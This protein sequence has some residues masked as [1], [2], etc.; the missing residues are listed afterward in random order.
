LLCVRPGR[1]RDRRRR[2]RRRARARAHARRR[3][4]HVSDRLRMRG[5]VATELVMNV[6]RS[7]RWDDDHLIVTP[8]RRF[9]RGRRVTREF[10]CARRVV[11]VGHVRDIYGGR[12]CRAQPLELGAAE[13]RAECF[14]RLSIRRRQRARARARPHC[15]DD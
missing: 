4:L 6:V 3:R 10:W 14:A 2:A 8:G 11:V 9:V 13:C 7:V 15:R 1:E 12:I 5:R